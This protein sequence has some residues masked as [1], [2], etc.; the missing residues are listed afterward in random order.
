MRVLINGP[1]PV[2]LAAPAP[3]GLDLAA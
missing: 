3:S 1:R 2:T